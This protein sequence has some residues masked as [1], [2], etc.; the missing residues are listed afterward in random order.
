M[1]QRKPAERSNEHGERHHSHKLRTLAAHDWSTTARSQM[2]KDQRRRGT[3]SCQTGTERVTIIFSEIGSLSY[4]SFWATENKTEVM[5]LHACRPLLKLPNI[6][7]SGG[8]RC[9]DCSQLNN[10]RIYSWEEPTQG[11]RPRFCFTKR[12]QKSFLIGVKQVSFIE[13]VSAL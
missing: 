4:R 7:A 11:V 2:D 8:L 9:S 5:I 12:M 10:T 13:C 1:E 6:G 3:T